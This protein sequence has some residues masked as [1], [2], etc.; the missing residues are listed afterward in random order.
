MAVQSNGQ[1]N[2]YLR[3]IPIL[4][5]IKRLISEFIQLNIS[6]PTLAVGILSDYGDNLWT[7]IIESE[8]SLIV[9]SII[10]LGQKLDSIAYL[11]NNE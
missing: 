2:F 11:V 4:F 7:L 5:L 6:I 9:N 10:V 3:I 8:F 1:V